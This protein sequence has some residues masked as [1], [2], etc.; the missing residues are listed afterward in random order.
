MRPGFYCHLPFLR[1]SGPSPLDIPPDSALIALPFEEW[2]CLEDPAMVQYERR[3]NSVSPVF[4]STLLPDGDQV[5]ALTAE[6]EQATEDFLDRV[7]AATILAM[8]MIAVAPSALSASYVVWRGLPPDPVDNR[9]I[10]GPPVY[11][12][13]IPANNEGIRIGKVAVWLQQRVPGGGHLEQWVVV[14]RFGPAQREWLLSQYAAAPDTIDAEAAGRFAASLQRLI[15]ADWGQHRYVALQFVDALTALWTSGTPLHEAFMLTAASLD[16][17]VN[18]EGER[19][20]G[21]VFG[22]RCAAWFAETATQRQSDEELFRAA[23]DLRG[24]F[25]HGND[26]DRYTRKFMKAIGGDG[27]E[28]LR[29]WTRQ[30]AWL[31]IDWLVAWFER[32]P[33]DTSGT[34]FRESLI[35]ATGMHDHEWAAARNRLVEGRTYARG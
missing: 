29:V 14:R 17:L 18:P 26:P 12:S 16:N 32:V 11:E 6:Q 33:D 2:L 5:G 21:K 27:D 22:A 20:L 30:I 19:P 35:E 25:V 9:G 23:Y 1:L 13:E 10:F 7:H 3:Y 15:A 8:P 31:A 28:D 24:S 4:A 34:K